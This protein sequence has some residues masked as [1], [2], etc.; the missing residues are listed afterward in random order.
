MRK[1][2]IENNNIILASKSP[3]RREILE[4]VGVSF[5]IEVSELP[6]VITQVEPSKIVLELS[7]Q[8][9]DEVYNKVLKDRINKVEA[10]DNEYI[11]IAADTV[12]EVDGHVMGKPLDR[13]D[14]YNMIKSISGRSHHVLTGVTLII[15][16]GIE[17]PR[18]VSFYEETSVEIYDMSEEEINRYIDSKE[19]YDK[20][21]AYAVQGAFAAYVKKLDGDYYNVVGLPIARIIRELKNFGIDMLSM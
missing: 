16:K 20:A 1:K 6:E 4:Q 9:A 13:D 19:P 3:R 12:V 11:I 7:M 18:K 8:K 14:A 15:C 17:E 10:T 5:D 2:Q 21:G